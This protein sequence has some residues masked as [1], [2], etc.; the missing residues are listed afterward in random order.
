[1]RDTASPQ[2]VKRLIVVGQGAAGLCAAV[3]ALTQARTQGVKVQ[4][5][6]LDAAPIDQSGG[7]TRW[8][9]SNI[10]LQANHQMAPGFVDDIMTES[11]GLADAAYFQQLAEQAP[12]MADWLVSLGIVFQSPPYYL[13]KGP[14]RIQPMGGGVAL[15]QAMLAQARALGLA[16]VYEFK[17]TD[18]IGDATQ[19]KGVVGVDAQGQRQ[20]YLADAVVLACGG[21]EGNPEMLK[22]HLGA[23]AENFHLISQGTAFN[24]GAGIRAAL[25]LGAEAAGDWQTGHAE[26][27]DPRSQ[28]PAPV[29]LV[30]PYGVVVN[31]Q[32]ERFFDEGAGL[33]HETWERF[34]HQMQHDLP[35]QQAYAILDAKLLSI[36]D[37]TRAI[38]SE[39][40]P[41]SAPSLEAL[42]Q[43]L[44]LPV[45][46]LRRT[47]ADF[48]AACLGSPEGFD[49]TR[50]DGL[51][52]APT[53]QPPK[54]NWARALDQGPYLAW[55]LVG[56]LVYTFGGIQTNPQAQVLSAHGPIRGL[57][58]AGEVTGHFYR[59]APNSVAMLR[60]LVFGK[61]A[62]EQCIKD[63]M[64]D[65]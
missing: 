38:R 35:E 33:M 26:P 11:G 57:Y 4:V 29:V 5:T 15:I 44:G 2:P 28:G 45:T 63:W 24:D 21:F 27:I 8:S 51:A 58:A 10:R 9:P 30:Y 49:P 60:A 41:V 19:V 48:N 3:S 61:I 14:A 39:V 65:E 7:N 34:S 62:G 40:P 6:L 17:L 53:G 56:A 46:T 54:S 20:T 59:L 64:H 42:A 37:Y 31:A 32:G 36:A 22:A 55:P 25:A 43:A 16:L 12:E 50:K 52:C 47:V 23:H 1:M 18:L 13:A